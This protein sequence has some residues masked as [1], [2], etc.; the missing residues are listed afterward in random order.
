MDPEIARLGRAVERLR[1]AVAI[2]GAAVVGLICYGAWLTAEVLDDEPAGS[3]G[4]LGSE[5]GGADI[6]ASFSPG[7]SA[8]VKTEAG[9][10][11]RVTLKEFTWRQ[12]P[13]ATLQVEG[14]RAEDTAGRWYFSLYDDTRLRLETELLDGGR[15]RVALAGSLPATGK[16]RYLHLDIDDSH[17]DLYFDV[18]QE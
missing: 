17:G 2:L 12:G 5:T 15:V 3:A 18:N 13:V 10:E 9:R 8:R 14:M 11:V 7:S 6:H 1:V 4:V 16:V